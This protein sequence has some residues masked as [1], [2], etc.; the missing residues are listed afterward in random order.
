MWNCS[1]VP[2]GADGTE[3]GPGGRG[4][5]QD[6]SSATG[7]HPQPALRI[8]GEGAHPALWKPLIAPEPFEPAAVEPGDSGAI[9]CNPHGPAPI[10]GKGRRQ[11]FEQARQSILL[12]EA[13][14]PVLTPSPA[15]P[16]RC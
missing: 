5:V 6:S 14:D 3:P 15:G 4:V 16:A 10:L 7:S 8:D 1:P 11:R 2:G 9:E 13:F 12:M